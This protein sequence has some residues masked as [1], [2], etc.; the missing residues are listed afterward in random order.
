MGPLLM[1]SGKDVKSKSILESGWALNPMAL[2]IIR[3]RG[4]DGDIHTHRIKE[5]GRRTKTE[6][7]VM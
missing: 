2:V 7:S 5:G 1:K 4:G 3:E 6:A